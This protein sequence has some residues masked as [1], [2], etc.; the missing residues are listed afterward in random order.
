MYRFDVRQKPFTLHGLAAGEEEFTRLPIA[1]FSNVSPKLANLAFKTSGARVRFSTNA[2]QI[3]LHMRL[4]DTAIKTHMTPLSTAGAEIWQGEGYDMRRIGVA[5]PT[6]AGSVPFEA[7]D[8]YVLE[9]NVL[10]N[11]SLSG[12]METVTVY[13]PIFAGVEKLEVELPMGTFLQP[14]SSY[15]ITPPIVFYG[16]SITQGACAGRPSLTYP[17][18]VSRKLDADFLNLGFAGNALGEKELARYI[19]TLNM[20]A[21][22]M[23]YD[24]NAPTAEYLEK[25]HWPFFEI[26]RSAHPKMP[27]LIISRPRCGHSEELTDACRLVIEK[28]YRMAKVAGDHHTIFL[29]GRDFFPLCEED[30]CLMDFIHPNDYGFRLISE[31]V[32]SALRSILVSHK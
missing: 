28:T 2:T 31:R 22:V 1:L 23:A 8:G 10:C 19:A 4:A 7:M 30:S 24:H 3:T 9:Q 12:K 26:I 29:D 6:A 15:T 18:I 11:V 5:R 25:T 20:T 27:I 16:S 14:P 21:F 17:A 32:L 13:L